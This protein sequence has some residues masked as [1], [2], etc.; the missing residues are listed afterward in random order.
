VGLDAVLGVVPEADLEY[1]LDVIVEEGAAEGMMTEEGLV[2][3]QMRLE[4]RIDV[5]AVVHSTERD[6]E[7]YFVR[8]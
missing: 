1:R 8:T 6:S 5:E 3:K 4:V 2:S 7:H